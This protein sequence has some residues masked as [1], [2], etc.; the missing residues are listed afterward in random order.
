MTGQL[1]ESVEKNNEMLASN[2][3][4]LGKEQLGQIMERNYDSLTTH[5]EVINAITEISRLYPPKAIVAEDIWTRLRDTPD[6]V[7]YAKQMLHYLVR[8]TESQYHSDPTSN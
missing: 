5:E 3:F 8:C 1:N 6:D 7:S 2:N 4:Q